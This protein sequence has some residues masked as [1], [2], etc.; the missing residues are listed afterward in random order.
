MLRTILIPVEDG[1]H[2]AVATEH[3]W[4][5]APL[6]KSRVYGIR[7]V[8][9]GTLE[10]GM[11]KTGEAR[12]LLDRDARQHLSAF[13][14]TCQAHGLRCKT[15]VIIGETVEEITLSVPRADMLIMGEALSVSGEEYKARKDVVREVLRRTARPM[16]IAREGHEKMKR[17]VVGYDGSEKGGHALQLAADLAERASSLLTVVVAADTRERGAALIDGA[18]VY[19]E[20]YHLTWKPVLFTGTPNE[21]LSHAAQDGPADLVVVGSHGHGR[22]HE[23]TF[24]STTNHVLEYIHTSILIYR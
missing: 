12:R 10:K 1:I 18:T 6:Y 7:I 5:L 8:D 16:L 20:A 22:L 9:I 24:G 3:L 13:D 2:N 17:I 19:L 11:H 15:D 23:L 14:Q 21:A 4:T